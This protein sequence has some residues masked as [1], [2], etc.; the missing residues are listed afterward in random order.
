MARLAFDLSIMRILLVEDDTFAR[1]IEVTALQE[2]GASK[3]TVAH[4]IG[5]ALDTLHRGVPC[6]LIVVDWNMPN[7]DGFD[8]VKAVHQNF[9]G[10]AV[11]MLTNN[12]GVDQ[13]KLAQAAGVDGCLIKPFSLDK[14]REAIQLALI[15]R[16]TGSDDITA[17]DHPEN[18]ELDEITTT[19]RSAITPDETKGTPERADASEAQQDANNFANKL[20]NQLDEFIGSLDIVNVHQADIIRLHVECLQAVLSSRPEALGHETHN[21]IVDGLSLAAD[22]VTNQN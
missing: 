3:V 20:S 11:L 12:E 16:L 18:P 13:I 2:L 7:F 17:R 19:I 21:L 22:L 10:L 14:L 8:L 5:D 4:D 1:E 15:S 9:P 6:D